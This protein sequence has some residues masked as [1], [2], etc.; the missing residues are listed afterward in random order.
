MTTKIDNKEH[1][2][3]E[4]ALEFLKN[5]TADT[6]KDKRGRWRTRSLFVDGFMG[7]NYD[8]YNYKPIF[9]IRDLRSFIHHEYG[10]IISLYEVYMHI[11]DVTEFRFGDFV[12]KDYDGWKNLTELGWMQK[13]LIK[14][15][16]HL[17]R[18]LISDAGMAYVDVMGN[19]SHSG[20]MRVQAASRAVEL[21]RSTDPDDVVTGK[22]RKVRVSKKDPQN[23][24]ETDEFSADLSRIVQFN[25]RM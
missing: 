11:G 4:E 23:V 7:T 6:F 25:T 9:S 12:F 16:D 22:G 18:K 24:A 10:L 14:F 5:A 3:L 19:K 8:N 2:H 17:S 15:R 20:A 13:D 1:P 21:T